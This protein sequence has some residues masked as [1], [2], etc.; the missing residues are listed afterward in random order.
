MAHSQLLDVQ[1]HTFAGGI[2]KPRPTTTRMFDTNVPVS[3]S[4][5]SI[6]GWGTMFGPLKM[7]LNCR[8]KD[9]ADTRLCPTQ[10][11]IL[12]RLL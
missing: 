5:F 4:A 9:T 1:S 6:I 10:D 12:R 2:V 8:G 3:M 11:A 7:S